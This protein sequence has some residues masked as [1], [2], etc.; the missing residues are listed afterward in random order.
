M[1]ADLLMST[2]VDRTTR[3]PT[4]TDESDMLSPVDIKKRRNLVLWFM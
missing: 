4:D 3:V 2:Q 1:L